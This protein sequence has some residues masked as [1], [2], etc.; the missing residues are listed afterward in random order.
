MMHYVFSMAVCGEEGA[1]QV[2]VLALHV[3][4]LL[5]EAVGSVYKKLLLSKMNVMYFKM[6]RQSMTGSSYFI[7]WVTKSEVFLPCLAGKSNMETW[8]RP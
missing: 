5:P 3:V 8:R 1:L 2:D 6:C 7:R 4:E